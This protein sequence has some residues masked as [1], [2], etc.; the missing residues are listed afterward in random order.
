MEEEKEIIMKSGLTWKSVL[1][2][3]FVTLTILPVNT[4]LFL[5]SGASIA[6]SAVYI[7]VILLTE[8]S[9]LIGAP[10]TKQ[11]I[12]IIFIMASVA[13]GSPVFLNSVYR[14]YYASS[15]I[16]WSFTDPYS[17]KP[18]PEV[19]P[20]WWTPTY[21]SPVYT[22]RTFLHKD[23]ILPIL[24]FQINGGILS[25][26]MEIALTMICSVM[27][28]EVESLPFPFANVNA[29]MIT[30]LTERTPERLKIFTLATM[31]SIPYAI[32]TYAIPT[33]MGGI[34]GSSLQLIPIPWLDL[35]VGM[36]G[37]ENYMPGAIFGL[38]TDPLTF[39]LGFLLPLHLQV[40]MLLGS[41]STWVFG[42]WLALTYFKNF[43]PEWAAEWKP[44]M[45]ISLIWQRSYLRVW[46]FPQVG[47]IAGLAIFTIVSQYKIISRALRGL[48]K[49]MSIRKRGYLPLPILLGMY[50]G[51]SLLSVL[52]FH[53]VVPDFPVW[54]SIIY[55]TGLSFLLAIVGARVRGETGLTITVPYVWYSAMCLTNY[56]K[57]DAWLGFN[58]II[59]GGLTTSW[60]EGIKTAYLT[61]TKPTDFFKAFIIT[62]VLYQVF[63]FIYVSFF[64]AIAQ[65]PSSFYRWTLIQWPIQAI[66]QSMWATRTILVKAD[67]IAYSMIG[68]IALGIL[69]EL[70]QKY[71]GIPFSTVGIITGTT[72]LPP[73]TITILIGGIM[74]RF[75]F[76]RIFG[77]ERWKVYQRI[78][79][80]GIA[81]GMGIVVGIS[82]A[83]VIMTKSAW[84]LPY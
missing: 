50:L 43:F 46:A 32:I 26:I 66:N 65:I 53:L 60:V 17:G 28:I 19:I 31:A 64:W 40:Y 25:I 24:L 84:I 1:A 44:G 2:L 11:E 67:I 4:Y 55:S 38:A 27:Y 14:C 47:F 83:I 18:L 54:I 23:W 81:A 79:V 78:I 8:I 30:T 73:Y 21:K 59:G 29:M 16:A 33:I 15:P 20:P 61:E 13:A 71:V 70:L 45:G 42:N 77:A 74:G 58:P 51:S 9:L 75:I 22:L 72:Q 41:I 82:A 56:N 37:L 35:T 10:M 69:G 7:T 48:S 76:Q 34:Y 36:F 49:S 5:I 12:F 52:I 39:S 68:I 3:I 63:S 6:A 80:A 57:I 62:F